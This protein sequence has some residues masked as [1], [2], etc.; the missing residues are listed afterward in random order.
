MSFA[1][2]AFADSQTASSPDASVK[3]TWKP[4]KISK[5]RA[6]NVALTL[7]AAGTRGRDRHDFQVTPRARRLPLV[8]AARDRRRRPQRARLAQPRSRRDAEQPQR[9]RRDS[10]ANARVDHARIDDHVGNGQ[11]VRRS[12]PDRRDP[13]GEPAG[14]PRVQARRWTRASVRPLRRGHRQRRQPL[15]RVRTQRARVRAGD[16]RRHHRPRA[17][18]QGRAVHLGHR[19]AA[20]RETAY[21]RIAADKHYLTDVV[22]GQPDRRRGRRADPEAVQ[23]TAVRDRP[24]RTA[25]RSSASSDRAI[26]GSSA[27]VLPVVPF[28]RSNG[29]KNSATTPA[30]R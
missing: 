3:T 8:Y 27:R 10:G 19:P 16:E 21:L 23:A 30:I 13:R 5:R 14:R 12:P 25:S 11:P 29:S 9:S 17:R 18:L 4:P 2:N 20:R 28:T 15:V 1:T 7:G 24:T 6:M 26:V 22:A